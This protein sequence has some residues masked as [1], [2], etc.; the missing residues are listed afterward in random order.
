LVAAPGTHRI[1]W[2][3]QLL[4]E[5]DLGPIAD[6]MRTALLLDSIARTFSV[7]ARSAALVKPPPAWLAEVIARRHPR[8]SREMRRSW[9][10]VDSELDRAVETVLLGAER[11]SA[12]P[13]DQPLTVLGT[14]EKST[15]GTATGNA[16][17]QSRCPSAAVP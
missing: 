6:P 8:F 14:E 15:G 5:L 2:I 9:T 1:A 11:A 13:Q 3:E 16:A 7:L 17:G 12:A 10:A 4:I